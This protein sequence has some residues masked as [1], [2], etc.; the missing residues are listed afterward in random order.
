MKPKEFMYSD[1]NMSFIR[2]EK[3]N[4]LKVLK[5][6]KGTIECEIKKSTEEGYYEETIIGYYVEELGQQPKF[7][8]P[9]EDISGYVFLDENEDFCAMWFDNISD[10]SENNNSE[11]FSG[12]KFWTKYAKKKYGWSP[13]TYTKGHKTRGYISAEERRFILNEYIDLVI[14]SNLYNQWNYIKIKVTKIMKSLKYSEHEIHLELIKIYLHSKKG[15]Y[16]Y[17]EFDLK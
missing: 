7:V 17:Y 9:T 3:E 2:T 16:N 11:P 12:T 6:H 8:W 13:I 1:W 4:F 15:H 14:S 5:E 10:F